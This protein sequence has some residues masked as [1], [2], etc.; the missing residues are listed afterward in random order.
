MKWMHNGKEFQDS[1]IPE[2]AHGFIYIIKIPIDGVVRYYIGK[3]N[4]YAVRNVK[5]GK[6]ELEA[7]VDKRGSKKK[8]VEKLNYQNTW[9]N[10]NQN[11]LNI[12]NEN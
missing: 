12:I 5:K 4:F 6:R 2:G 8:R 3:K 7:M 10:V 11:L 9:N 1:D